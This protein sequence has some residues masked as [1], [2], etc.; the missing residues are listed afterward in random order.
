MQHFPFRLALSNLL[1]TYTRALQPAPATPCTSLL[2]FA[3]LFCPLHASYP[4]LCALRPVVTTIPDT[5]QR[6]HTPPHNSAL[7]I[8]PQALDTFS[9]L[10]DYID[11]FVSLC[12]CCIAALFCLRAISCLYLCAM[13]C[14]MAL[15]STDGICFPCCL[16]LI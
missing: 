7:Y 5:H 4:K 1:G 2:C 12:C 16:Y 14:N 15:A 11:T 8:L 13:D 3:R 9:S 6:C 10:F